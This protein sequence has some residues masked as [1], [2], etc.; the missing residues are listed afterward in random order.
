MHV[1]GPD[2]GDTKGPAAPTTDVPCMPLVTC[3]KHVEVPNLYAHVHH[4]AAG[5]WNQNVPVAIKT[6][7]FELELEPVPCMARAMPSASTIRTGQ[8]SIIIL[9]SNF[10][11]RTSQQPNS[12]NS[13]SVLSN[14]TGGMLHNQGRVS[15]DFQRCSKG[16]VSEDHESHA[17]YS[18]DAHSQA[19]IG[20][21]HL[22]DSLCESGPELYLE[23]AEH[24]TEAP[25]HSTTTFI[26]PIGDSTTAHY[27]GDGRQ[28]CSD[29]RPRIHETTPPRPATNNIS[30]EHVQHNIDH[31]ILTISNNITL[32]INKVV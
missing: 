15:G 13:R 27:N 20:T 29:P 4:T 11:S 24:H 31:A 28:D 8:P 18:D 21:D 6:I 10:H 16:T 14:K 3:V 12:V 9:L 17:P 30:S 19:T 25:S 26:H 2:H 1:D 32:F 23:L 7:I 5:L 22:T